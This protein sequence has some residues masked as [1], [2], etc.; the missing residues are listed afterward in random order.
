VDA[1]IDASLLV[2]S[3]SF[4]RSKEW[5]QIIADGSLS[6]PILASSNSPDDN[7]YTNIAQIPKSS[8]HVFPVGRTIPKNTLAP[9]SR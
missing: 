5:A 4:E 8:H 7:E 1:A 2:G 6:A 9:H 3:S